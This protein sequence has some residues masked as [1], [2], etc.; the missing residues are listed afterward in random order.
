MLI[1]CLEG[2]GHCVFLGIGILPGPKSNSSYKK[3]SVARV[4]S[5]MMEGHLRISAPVFSLN[6]VS[7]VAIVRE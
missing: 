1:A 2:F 5:L 4:T 3:E 6:L 7:S